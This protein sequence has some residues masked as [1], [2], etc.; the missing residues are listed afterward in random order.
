[1]QNTFT[2]N[3]CGHQFAGNPQA[4]VQNPTCP[5]C[6]TF[7]QIIGAD[8]QFVNQPQTVVRMQHP[9]AGRANPYQQAP[10][11]SPGLQKDYVEVDGGAM[12]G[13]TKSNKNL[14]TMVIIGVT[15]ISLIGFFWFI[16][17]AF[18]GD[19]SAEL[20]Q[21]IEIVQDP[22]DYEKSV[23]SAISNA[24]AILN[25][26]EGAEI[27]ESTDF[28]EVVEIINNTP[29]CDQL[30]MPNPP[31]PGSPFKA[32]GF[33]IKAPYKRNKQ[34]NHGFVM[35]LYYKTMDEAVAAGK[36]VETYFSGTKLN[37]GHGQDS[38]LWFVGYTGVRYPGS[39]AS[40]IV[41]ARKAGPPTESKQYQ[42]RQAGAAPGYEE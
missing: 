35:L 19:R 38:G 34:M 26:I 9:G 39:M 4:L 22:V 20:K 41:E 32:K 29:N 1:M 16:I 13:T 23:N 14:T 40:R 36:E 42:N 15:G 12:L 8:G 33:I 21:E 2:C 5:R 37:Y 17:T 27:I 10:Q 11:Q 18:E 3:A 24:R 25:R 31:I 30:V 7:G 28:S 6:Q